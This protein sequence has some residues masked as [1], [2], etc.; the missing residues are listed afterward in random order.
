MASFIPEKQKLPPFHPTIEKSNHV[1]KAKNEGQCP[2]FL[3]HIKVESF[4]ACRRLLSSLRLL[5]IS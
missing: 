3:F 5:L 1:F 4:G 2:E